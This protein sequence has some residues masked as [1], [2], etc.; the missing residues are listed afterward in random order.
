VSQAAQK[1]S[2]VGS[3]QQ[4]LK[5]LVQASAVFD[6]PTGQDRAGRT[7][8]TAQEHEPPGSAVG[9]NFW[10]YV[11]RVDKQGVCVMWRYKMLC[12]P[13]DRNCPA[14]SIWAST[15]AWRRAVLVSQSGASAEQTRVPMS[16]QQ[17]MMCGS[18]KQGPA[19][20][21]CHSPTSAVPAEAQQGERVRAAACSGR[22]HLRQSSK[23]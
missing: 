10:T 22:S 21:T 19:K 8:T 13:A 7:C 20:L 16:V 5:Q 9:T 11:M 18:S 2:R 15:D 23:Q 14:A 6:A 17:C 12:R 3:G 1:L 4:R